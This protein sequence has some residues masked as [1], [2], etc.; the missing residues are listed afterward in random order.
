M[1]VGVQYMSIDADFAQLAEDLPPEDL[2]RVLDV[3]EADVRRLVASL[4]TAAVAGD[5]AGF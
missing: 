3:F 1:R 4:D 2:R 5:V